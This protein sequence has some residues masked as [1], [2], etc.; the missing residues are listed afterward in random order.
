MHKNY[1]S[2]RR[3]GLNSIWKDH[4]THTHTHKC[5]YIIHQGE[6]QASLLLPVIPLVCICNVGSRQPGPAQPSRL[7]SRGKELG[8]S[9][10]NKL[11]A[12]L[13]EQIF[14]KMKTA[15]ILRWTGWWR[16]WW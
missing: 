8:T 10:I 1:V 11:W 2:I 3:A 5:V 12:V 14:Q 15:G 16:W 13:A 4:F 6:T 7:V 9:P